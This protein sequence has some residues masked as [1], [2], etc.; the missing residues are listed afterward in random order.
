MERIQR[1]VRAKQ[2]L[3]SLSR[4]AKGDVLTFLTPLSRSGEMLK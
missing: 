2:R 4:A 3:V 1:L